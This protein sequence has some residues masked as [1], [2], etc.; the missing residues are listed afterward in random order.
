[1]K[2]FDYL[3]QYVATFTN[4]T[5]NFCIDL[6][7]MFTMFSNKNNNNSNNHD[8]NSE[9]ANGS[10]SGSGNFNV[11]GENRLLYQNERSGNNNENQQLS[12]SSQRQATSQQHQDQASSYIARPSFGLIDFV[13][14][15]TLGMLKKSIFTFFFHTIF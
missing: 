4:F 6:S 2:H 12:Q 11:N 5:C 14:L 15:R 7:R 10:S 8:C 9:G 1:M 3:N 13:L